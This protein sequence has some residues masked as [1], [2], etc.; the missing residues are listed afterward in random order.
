[1]VD[2][3]LS[4]RFS[5]K[6]AH[7]TQASLSARI[8][9]DDKLSAK[10]SFVGG[11]DVAYINDISIGAVVVLDFDTLK[12]VES[13]TVFCK[14][15]FP[16]IPTLLSF[17]EIPPAVQSAR[18]LSIQPDVLLVDGH[19][20][21]HPYRCGFASHL[22]LILRIPTIGVA[23]DRLI[24][25]I[26]DVTTCGYARITDQNDVVGAEV[27]TKNEC[28]PVYVSVGHMISLETAVRIVKFCA[29]H[30]RIPE[31]IRIAHETAST[32]KRKLHTFPCMKH[33]RTE[34]EKDKQATRKP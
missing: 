10:I 25:K 20:F 23:K 33:A 2:V 11:V 8:I 4:S 1:M 5:V 24:G 15:V 19:G 22:G 34:E 6:K 17:R 9:F 7:E 28:R 16:Y 29:N 30:S 31:P 12:V 21:A 27:I 18:R 32:E 3:H 14:T 13:Q 26:A